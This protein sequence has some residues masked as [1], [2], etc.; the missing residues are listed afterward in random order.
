MNY[1]IE[2]NNDG[3]ENKVNKFLILSKFEEDEKS[4]YKIFIAQLM[5]NRRREA[6][7]NRS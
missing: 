5:S 1:I 7:K 3:C 4:K 2:T 6:E